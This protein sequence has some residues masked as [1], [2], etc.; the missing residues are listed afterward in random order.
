M[1]S[2]SA[3][4][5]RLCAAC[6]GP[7]DSGPFGLRCARCVLSLVATAED[8]E[9]AQA[10]ELFPELDLQEQV[11]RGGFGA[12]YRARHRRMKR[13][14]ALKFLN[15]VL[16]RNPEAVALF[17]QEMIAVGG[18]DHP[19]IVRAHDAGE[20]EGQ[21][22][23]IM[24]YV[25]GLDCGALVRKH[26]RLPVAESCEIIRQAALALEHAHRQ[27]FVHRDVK[28]GNV[29][30]TKGTQTVDATAATEAGPAAQGTAL[31]AAQVKVLDFGLAGLAVAP[32]FAQPRAAEGSSLFLGTLD[33]IP[34]E[35]IESPATV[36]ARADVY[37][38]GATFWRLLTGQV[39]RSGPETEGSLFVRMRH[40]TSE[41]VP[42]L[43]TVRP[44]VPRPLVA[45]CDAM[46]S[47]DREKRPANAAE[48]ARQLEPW[49]A[50]ADLPRLF[51]EGPLEEKPL[52]FPKKSRRAWWLAGAAGAAVAAAVLTISSLGLY[53]PETGAPAGRPVFSAELTKQR[54]LDEGSMPR[55]LSPDWAP[56]GEIARSEVLTSARFLPD[57]RL[58][59]L[60]SGNRIFTARP[61]ESGQVLLVPSPGGKGDILA[62]G[63][64][65]GHVVWRNLDDLT[66]APIQRM[67]PDGTMLP[68]LGYDLASDLL[69][70]THEFVRLLRK[71]TKG[72]KEEAYPWGFAFVREGAV[73]P[74]TGLRAGDV[75]CADE[76][77][78]TLIDNVL[79]SNPGLWRFRLDDD[80]PAV[81]VASLG[82]RGHYP[83]DVAVSRHGVFLL[84][85]S[86]TIPS[87]PVSDPDNFNRRLY[88]MDK[89]GFR[90]CVLDQPLHDPTGLAADPLSADLYAIQGGLMP[91]A[92][93]AIQR[94]LRLR[95]MGGDRYAVGVVAERFGKL[96]LCGIAFSPD[97][98]HMAITD[99]GN[100]VVV[101]L[102]RKG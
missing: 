29:M 72:E 52:V 78:R 69:P 71:D 90:P 18:L 9:L 66:G 46:L 80:K 47:L 20:R 81:R 68:P 82:T 36:D 12:V 24:E 35:Q 10:A 100:R 88:R 41:P 73:P 49:G 93:T 97:G 54:A 31:V 59:Y 101:L 5:D 86:E 76:G 27:G 87:R 79:D 51:T 85:R 91:S 23:L 92:S 25:D 50:G 94:V 8:D 67:K 7:L 63:P 102:A 1:E 37:S 53:A 62:A 6:G 65:S 89:A 4:H 22:Y 38:L 58:V 55:L 30:V 39:P 77:H 57:G 32:V 61:G 43:A 60:Y 42:S 84:N 16:A 13:P 75:L 26:G 19:G 99:V 70:A 98:K 56:A 45:L 64:D 96:G 3:S 48:V 2:A 14:V 17:E 21:W 74:D 44:D 33:Y 40:I 83:M 15:S 28:P 34:P 95:P 11:A